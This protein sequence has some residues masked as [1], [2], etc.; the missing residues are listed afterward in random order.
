[1]QQASSKNHPRA[2]RTRKAVV[3][4][5]ARGDQEQ[6]HLDKQQYLDRLKA[7]AVH[8]R[9]LAEAASDA[10]ARQALLEIASDIE[11]AIPI[12]DPDARRD[13]GE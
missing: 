11:A 8:C 10:E 2:Q 9:N 4:A 7:N 12:V 3:G 1:M 5:D 13:D 6:H